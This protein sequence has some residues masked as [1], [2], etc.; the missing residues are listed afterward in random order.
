MSPPSYS[1]A[2]PAPLISD[3]DVVIMYDS[4]GEEFKR[5]HRAGTIYWS[6]EQHRPVSLSWLTESCRV[7]CGGGDVEGVPPLQQIPQAQVMAEEFARVLAWAWGPLTLEW[8]QIK[9]PC[10]LCAQQGKA[11]IFDAPSVGLQ[12]DTSICLPCCAS[13]EKC[14]ISLEWQAVCIA[15][16][17][18][19]D[20]DWV[21]S[22]LGKAWKTR[23]LGEVSTGWSAGQVGP[24]WG[25]WREGASSAADRGKWGQ[26]PMSQPPELQ[27]GMARVGR[28]LAGHQQ[29]NAV[30]PG[31]WWEVAADAGKALLGLVEVLAVV[32]AQ[33]KIDL[34][35]GMVGVLGE[36]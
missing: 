24:P 30:A 21:W 25:G 22:Q 26:M 29:H 19:W 12:H 35:V 11:C 13:H 33:M 3:V 10:V 1:A 2:S 28:L 15:V 23:M 9:A 18:G 34:G 31:S 7:V 14:S 16:E 32:Q 5:W 6:H 4:E 17:Q 27:Q 20:E 36:E 8:C